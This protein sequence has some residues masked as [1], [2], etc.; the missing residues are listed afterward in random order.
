MLFGVLDLNYDDAIWTLELN[1]MFCFSCFI[2]QILLVLVL[3]H[4]YSIPRIKIHRYCNAHTAP[5]A[6]YSTS[7]WKKIYLCHH[8]ALGQLSYL[9]L[10]T[11]SNSKLI[12][13]SELK[14]INFFL[15]RVHTL[16][17]TG[18]VNYIVLQCYCHVIFCELRP[19]VE[20]MKKKFQ[21]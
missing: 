1:S 18:K 13:Y 12:P 19:T 15:I 2:V 6:Y 9:L 20:W 3:V 4:I 11:F 16:F 10:T 8:A 17:P 14:I 7:V 5:Y 21:Q